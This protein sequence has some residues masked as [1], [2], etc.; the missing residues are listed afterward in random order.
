MSSKS[1]HHQ[2]RTDEEKQHDGEKLLD[3]KDK[4]EKNT[5]IDGKFFTRR[6]YP[7]PTP[8]QTISPSPSQAGLSSLM[9]TTAVVPTSTGTSFVSSSY[10]NKDTG[11]IVYESSCSV[12]AT[13]IGL[14]TTDVE[15]VL[16][17]F[18]YSITLLSSSTSN[19]AISDDDYNLYLGKI[20]EILHNHLSLDLI[21]DCSFS[22]PNRQKSFEIMSINSSP[23]DSLAASG[24][25]ASS[26]SGNHNCRVVHGYVTANIFYL[27]D[28]RRRKLQ[29]TS[30]VDPA[31]AKAFGKSIDQCITTY[32]AD[33]SVEMRFLGITNNGA[34]NQLGNTADPNVPRPSSSAVVES[35]N[36][37]NSGSAV[38]VNN[39]GGGATVI[40]VAAIVFLT[41]LFVTARKVRR[42]FYGFSKGQPELVQ[43]ENDEDLHSSRDEFQTTIV[44][45]ENNLQQHEDEQHI[46]VISQHNTRTVSNNIHNVKSDS[47]DS[48][49]NSNY[50][51]HNSADN[52]DED[53]TE[54]DDES[55]LEIMHTA[56]STK[57][58][59][60]QTKPPLFLSTSEETNKDELRRQRFFRIRSNTS[61]INKS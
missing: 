49:G 19:L 35:Q 26:C 9:P 13:D 16:V 38:R 18:D 7:T 28:R 53:Y 10:T 56:A 31:I 20:E 54:A 37:N 33:N 32:S 51:H 55:G 6:N 15:P 29:L 58:Y 59:Q 14:Q 43:Q 21:Q 25:E 46:E 41:A 17:S 11:F 45:N 44:N 30:I 39:I 48:N 8:V 24:D 52:Y 5:K 47:T 50:H 4:K 12:A 2:R 1:I 42:R 36:A 22:D 61:S 40:A 57:I 60:P 23:T 27:V 34:Y 3:F